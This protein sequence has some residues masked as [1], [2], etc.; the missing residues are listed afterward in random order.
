MSAF[1]YGANQAETEKSH[2]TCIHFVSLDFVSGLLLANTTPS[3]FTWGGQ[4][5]LGL[6]YV[7]GISEIAEDAML[8]PNGVTLQ[9]SGVDSTVITAAMTEG[10]HGRAIS[11]WEGYLGETTQQLVADPELIFRGIMDVMTV[12]LGEGTALVTVKCE[13]E[14]ARWQRH[15]GLLYTHESQQTIFPGDKGLDQVLKIQNRRLNWDGKWSLGTNFS[16]RA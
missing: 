6:G 11:I 3:T 8:R 16:G 4:D 2:V 12:E 9:L 7:G 10:Y 5:Y 1:T 13:G 15:R 14:L